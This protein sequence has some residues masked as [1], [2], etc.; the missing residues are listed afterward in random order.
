MA[1]RRRHR[2]GG[3]RGWGYLLSFL[4]GVLLTAGLTFWLL[5]EHPPSPE[6]FSQSVRLAHQIVQSQLYE[7]GIAK[8]DIIAE[9]S[10]PRRQGELTWVQSYLKVL[11]PRSLSHP[12]IED[13]LRRALSTLERPVAIEASQAPDAFQLEVKVQDRITHQLVFVSPQIRNSRPSSRARVAVVIDDLGEEN[14]LS[15]ELLDA[16]LPITFSIL[17]FSP[18]SKRL[19]LE[20]HKRGKEVILHLPM[21][22]HG[23]PGSNPGEGVLLHGMDQKSLLGQLSKDLEAVP[24]VLG[25][26]NH[27]GSRFMEDPE[28]LRILFKELKRQGLYFLD[29]LTTPKSAGLR[30]AREVGLRATERS[31]FLDH[32]LA[33]GDIRERLDTLAQVALSAGRAVGIGHPHAST[34][35]LLK[36]A[37]PRWK[38]KGIAF[39]SLS[40]VME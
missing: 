2:R 37:V 1:R 8:R 6:D 13:H 5:Q 21:E 17:P 20:A 22:P 32:S 15:H 18:Y 35:K 4:V 34:V 11:T 28:K 7:M 40:E 33:E 38:E 23:Y 27:M 12:L 24:H 19:A 39:V 36:E 26:S 3:G 31:V 30:T 16:N 10:S 9:K 29:S 25:A 14:H